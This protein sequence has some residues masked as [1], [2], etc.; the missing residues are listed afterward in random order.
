MNIVNK[1]MDVISQC[2]YKLAKS[3][4]LSQ[5]F[6]LK[7]KFKKENIYNYKYNKKS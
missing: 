4:G 2:L 1:R 3:M 6:A 5:F 7:A